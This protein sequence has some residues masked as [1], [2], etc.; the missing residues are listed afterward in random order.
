MMIHSGMELNMDLEDLKPFSKGN[1]RY[2]FK[3][4]DESLKKTK[5]FILKLLDEMVLGTWKHYDMPM[6]PN[7]S[8]ITKLKLSGPDSSNF[9]TYKLISV[10]TDNYAEENKKKELI[11]VG[12]LGAINWQERIKKAMNKLWKNK[13]NF[14]EEISNE[15]LENIVSEVPFYANVNLKEI[16]QNRIPRE[17]K[18][19]KKR[20][21]KV[22][23]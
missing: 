5:L 8:V 15:I 21:F 16:L 7:R 11:S 23:Y 2:N 10:G 12:Y 1:K 19:R 3:E 13:W 20:K 6:K 9:N 4:N 17:K 22:L 18:E 14:G